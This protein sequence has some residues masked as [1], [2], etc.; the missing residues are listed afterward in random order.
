MKY[1]KYFILSSPWLFFIGMEIAFYLRAKAK[2][3][4]T[5]WQAI[6][7]VPKGLISPF[8][9]RDDG[10]FWLPEFATLG[11]ILIVSFFIVC[12]IKWK[13]KIWLLLVIQWLYMLIIYWL[14]IA[15]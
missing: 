10:R 3:D 7:S 9:Q 4:I 6:Q 12:L 13:H 11:F 14:L 8:W 1:F 5:I 15:P 2:W